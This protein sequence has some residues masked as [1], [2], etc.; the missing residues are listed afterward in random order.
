MRIRDWSSDVCSSDLIA[1]LV[2]HRSPKP[3]VVGSSP[4]APARPASQRD[5]ETPKASLRTQGKQR[6]TSRGRPSASQVPPLQP[7]PF[8][9]IFGV[10]TRV[11]PQTLGYEILA[12]FT[13]VWIQRQP[14]QHRTAGADAG[15]EA[16]HEG[17]Q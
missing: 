3:R 16:I 6:V 11:L 10:G 9:V 2:E 14:H 8:F 1:Q 4:T 7:N 12:G 15:T 13:N 17:E 5:P